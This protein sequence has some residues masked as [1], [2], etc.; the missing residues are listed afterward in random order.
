MIH[1]FTS[2]YPYLDRG[3]AALE[4]VSANLRR[5]FGAVSAAP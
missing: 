4:E 5:V 1:T 2:L 3:R